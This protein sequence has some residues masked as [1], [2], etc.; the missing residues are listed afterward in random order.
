[1]TDLHIPLAFGEDAQCEEG[2]YDGRGE[3]SVAKV[4]EDEVDCGCEPG[5]EQAVADAAQENEDDGA[6][7]EVILA[8]VAFDSAVDVVAVDDEQCSGESGGDK[9]QMG[10]EPGG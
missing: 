7:D 6:N 3:V 10:F 1:M 8:K 5:C 9:G 4:E 2:E